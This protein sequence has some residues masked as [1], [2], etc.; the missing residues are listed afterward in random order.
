VTDQGSPALSNS[1]VV[2]I[3]VSPVNEFLPQFTHKQSVSII[4]KENQHPGNGLVLFDVNA[5]DEDFGEQGMSTG[6]YTS[7]LK[8]EIFS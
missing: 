4:V 6:R 2:T 7:R 1:N 3:H 5:T 8:R